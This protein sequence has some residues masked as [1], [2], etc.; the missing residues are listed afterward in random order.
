MDWEFFK[1]ESEKGLCVSLQL[2]EP[3]GTSCNIHNVLGFR[4]TLKD[5]MKMNAVQIKVLWR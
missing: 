5:I 2:Q 1:L 4:C 3:S